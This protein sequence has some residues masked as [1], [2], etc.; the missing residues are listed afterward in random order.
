MVTE[1]A[2]CFERGYVAVFVFR[3]RAKVNSR[4]FPWRGS[5]E[6]THESG[7]LLPLLI[8]HAPFA[9][10]R[11]VEPAVP[12]LARVSSLYYVNAGPY[13]R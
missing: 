7:G 9:D 13:F 8:A 6:D 2:L 5:V 4:R 3:L 10:R 12:W 11:L 1:A